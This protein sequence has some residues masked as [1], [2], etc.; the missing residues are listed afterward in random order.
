MIADR[1]PPTH[2]LRLL[3]STERACRLQT[4]AKAAALEQGVDGEVSGE[5]LH[6]FTSRMYGVPRTP[7]RTTE[8]QLDDVRFSEVTPFIGGKNDNSESCRSA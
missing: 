1:S 4:V 5:N 8:N 7:A 3:A 2:R 6:T